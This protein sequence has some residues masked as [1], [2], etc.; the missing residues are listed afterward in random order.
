[1]CKK[2]FHWSRN[3]CLTKCP[4]KKLDRLVVKK[5]VSRSTSEIDKGETAY[6]YKIVAWM[7][8]SCQTASNLFADGSYH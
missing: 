2:D 6:A 8:V 7:F 1:V 3:D 5:F 4:E